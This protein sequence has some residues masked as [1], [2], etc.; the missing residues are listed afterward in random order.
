MFVTVEPKYSGLINNRMK[1]YQK[2]G[3]LTDLVIRCGQRTIQAHKIIMASASKVFE[4]L[5]ETGAQEFEIDDRFVSVVDLLIDI[6][7]CGESQFETDYQKA[8]VSQILI[9]NLILI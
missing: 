4:R 9:S 7:Y 8:R 2:D 1:N 3:I 6:C 5:L